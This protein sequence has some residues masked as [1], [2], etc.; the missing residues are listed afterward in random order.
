MRVRR[1]PTPLSEGLVLTFDVGGTSTRAGIYH[2]VADR[3]VASRKVP[4]PSFHALGVP[5]GP[6]LRAHLYA[7][8]RELGRSLFP[9]A[10]PTAVAVGFP[11]PMDREGRIAAVPTVWGD[12]PTLPP[13]EVRDSIESLWPEAGVYLMN[14]VTAASHRYLRTS[15]DDLC[16]ITVSTGIGHKVV[17]DGRVR[18]GPNGRGG[19]IGHW[20]V[21]RDPNA[22]VCQCG[23]RGHLGALAS[24]TATAH[25]LSKLAATQPDLFDRSALAFAWD[26]EHGRVDNEAFVAA[27][28]EDDPLAV[29][30][31]GEMAALLG[32]A[33]ATLHLGVGVERFVLI[34]GFALALGDRYRARV[35]AAAALGSWRGGLETVVSVELGAADDE[36]GLLGAGR[37]AA[38]WETDRV[39]FW[40]QRR[41]AA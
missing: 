41:A 8:M 35:E 28:H 6:D 36:S 7:A 27:F 24:G 37:Y 39:L 11:G 30:V 19:E 2:P 22:P 38:A 40:E 26:P 13:S 31:V 16:V 34:G 17:C 29:R 23:G 15:A 9:E 25:H 3:V 32:D 12:D 5:P 4:T 33:V 10:P 14:D 20:R 18:T 21:S 1:P